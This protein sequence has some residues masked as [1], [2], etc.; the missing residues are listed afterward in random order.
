[1]NVTLVRR[2]GKCVACDSPAEELGRHG[3]EPGV[4]NGCETERV[5]VLDGRWETLLVRLACRI[6]ADH[7]IWRVIQANV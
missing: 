4:V 3:V 1:M 5:G 7:E 6:R 2:I